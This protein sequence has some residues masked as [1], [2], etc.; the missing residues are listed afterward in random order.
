MWLDRI[1]NGP[2]DHFLEV[3]ISNVKQELALD[4][5]HFFVSM[6]IQDMEDGH[7]FSV[8]TY[9]MKFG[10][11]TSWYI[12]NNSLITACDWIEFS[13]VLLI[14]FL[15]SLSVMWS[16]NW[17]LTRHISLFRWLFRIWKMAIS[18]Q[19]IISEWNLV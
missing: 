17:L 6:V 18:S 3:L 8:E 16:K 11:Q 9:W 7:F 15:R 2:P 19:L 13:M 12:K 5:P 14:I 4:S 10:V 1:L